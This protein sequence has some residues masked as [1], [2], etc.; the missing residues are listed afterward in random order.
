M[1]APHLSSPDISIQKH[2]AR[3]A[4]LVAREGQDP[5]LG[6]GLA[7]H[8]LAGVRLA[9]AVAVSGFWPMAGEIDIRPLL[10]ALHARGHP[11]L[12]LHTPKLGNPLV[13][14]HWHPGAT[15]VRER[16][17]SERPTGEIG[18]PAVLFVPLLAFDRLGHRLG[19]GGGFYD[20]TLA[21]LPHAV[22]IGCGFA[23]QEVDAV[24]VSHHDARLHAVATELGVIRFKD[25]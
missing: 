10:T 12:L 25:L 21:L 7:K 2:E 3:A 14:R 23:A 11:V 18:E 4:A 16:F 19:Y 17:G 24:P 5:G 9:P 13:F 15:M 1:A 20:R 8:V 22:A 6:E